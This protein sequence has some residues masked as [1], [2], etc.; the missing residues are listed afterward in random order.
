MKRTI[1]ASFILLAF[2]A[3]AEQAKSDAQ[4]IEQ[5]EIS[6][7]ATSKVLYQLQSAVTAYYLEKGGWPSALS[8]IVSGSEPFYNGSLTTALGTFSSDITG[9]AFILKFSARNSNENTLA[10]VKS[11]AD[12]SSSMYANGVFE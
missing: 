8:Q 1:L 6:V 7:N 4:T 12:L 10:M 9:K 3:I 11:V 5:R 2:P